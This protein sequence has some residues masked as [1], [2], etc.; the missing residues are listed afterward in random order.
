MDADFSDQMD[1]DGICEEIL[2]RIDVF[3]SF[4]AS[5]FLDIAELDC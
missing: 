2:E 1:A 5:E 3:D 4:L